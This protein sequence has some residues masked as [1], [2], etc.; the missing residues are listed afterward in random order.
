MSIKVDF[1]STRHEGNRGEAQ[2]QPH[3]FLPSELD[4]GEWPVNT[5]LYLVKETWYH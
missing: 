2:V 5:S 1:P 4:S 3:K